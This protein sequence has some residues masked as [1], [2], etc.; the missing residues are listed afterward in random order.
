M[1]YAIFFGILSVV[2]VVLWLNAD[3]KRI[4]VEET[5]TKMEVAIETAIDNLEKAKTKPD[6]RKIS[7][8]LKMFLNVQSS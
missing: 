6:V 1:S 8:A 7:N 5:L 4:D 2:F 3:G